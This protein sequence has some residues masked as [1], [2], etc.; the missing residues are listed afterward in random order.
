VIVGKK[1][2]SA[3]SKT[4]CDCVD[5][6]IDPDIALLFLASDAEDL[7][8]MSVL[9]WDLPISQALSPIHQT[10][11]GLPRDDSMVS[12]KKGFLLWDSRCASA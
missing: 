10:K 3:I 12:A 8:H 11:S 5:S 6:C 4:I 9:R 1:E 2:P 7:V